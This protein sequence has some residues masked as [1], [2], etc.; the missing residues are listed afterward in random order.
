MY[1]RLLTTSFGTRR[2]AWLTIAAWLVLIGV[3]TSLAPS[4][5]DVKSAGNG[6]P[7][8]SAPSVKGED[9]LR[10]AFPSRDDV[11]PA[12]IAVRADTAADTRRATVAVVRALQQD[13]GTRTLAPISVL[14]ADPRSGLRPGDDCVPGSPQGAESA[15]GRTRTVVVP[16]VGDDPTS[17]DFR[18]TVDEVRDRVAA[19]AGEGATTH[20]TGPAGII[21]DTVKVFSSGDRVLLFGTIGLV[22]VILL[23]VYRAPLL[24]LLPLLAVGMAMR[25]AQTVGA[26]LADAGVIEVTGQT[27]SIM[28]VLLFGVGT[29]YALL[30]TARYREELKD[31]GPDGDRHAA[32]VR[33]MGRT[34]EVLASSAGTIVL[35]M[36]ALLFTASPSLRGFG[37]YLALGVVSMAL[38]AATLFPAL[39]LVAGRAAFW[40]GGM[41]RAASRVE[42]PLWRRIAATV[43]ARPVATAAVSLGLLVALSAGLVGYKETFNSVSGFRVDTDSAAGQRLIADH[44]GPGEIAPVTLLVEGNGLTPAR[45]A[46]VADGLQADNPDVAHAQAGP[47]DVAADAQTG[48]VTI[49]LAHDPYQPDAM[50]ALPGLERDAVAQLSADGVTGARATATGE[51]AETADVRAT[52]DHDIVLLIPLMLV[53]VGAV[54]GLLLRSLLA[55]LYLMAALI[56][57]FAATLGLTVLIAVTAQGDDG[58]GNRVTVYVFVFSIALGVDYTIFLVSRLR[59]ELDAGAAMRAALTTSLVRTG[60]VVSSA[61]VILAATFSVLMTQPIR[62]LYQFGMAMALGLLLDTFVVRPFLVPAVIHL[63]GERAL[64]PYRPRA[65]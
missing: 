60:G 11:L 27:A 40:P 20:V 61:G 45:L 37:P 38:V 51:T 26:L 24:A 9:R 54:L 7:P 58:I 47:R 53:T 31:A 35:A 5:D 15:D 59:Q 16:I 18:T 28:T 8:A 12:V 52:L 1:R 46:A 6:G 42:S 2:R 19:A 25:L 14:C 29:D 33:A 64:W 32:M 4:L 65:R 21:T 39:V 62:E 63:L 56:V 23:L 49:V 17:D 48:R 43:D 10:E 36:A 50:N 13:A 34:G 41:R 55:P 30:I 3:L 57:S 44:I 22:L